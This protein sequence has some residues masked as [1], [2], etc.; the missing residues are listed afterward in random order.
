MLLLCWVLRTEQETSMTA[1]KYTFRLPE[2]F[3]QCQ[4]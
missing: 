4:T 1:I 2:G 3:E